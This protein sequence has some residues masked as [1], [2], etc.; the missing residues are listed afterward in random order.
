MH[1]SKNPRLGGDLGFGLNKLLSYLQH[2]TIQITMKLL[3]L[4]RSEIY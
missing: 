3:A 2:P 4:V 1:E